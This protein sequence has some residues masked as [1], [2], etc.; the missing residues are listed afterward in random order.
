LESHLQWRSA[1]LSPHLYQQVLSPLFLIL[2]IL[3]SVRW[4]HRVILICI[5][6]T[7]LCW[8]FYVEVLDSLGLEFCAR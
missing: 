2:A 1:P 7:I 4:N 5:S 3:V 8:S 6:L